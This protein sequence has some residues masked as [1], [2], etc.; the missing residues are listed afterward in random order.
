MDLTHRVADKQ[1]VG[2]ARI[3]YHISYP[4]VLV[5]PVLFMVI[6]LF[7]ARN[8]FGQEWEV[9]TFSTA[10]IPTVTGLIA[11]F[12]RQE[13]Q[14]VTSDL[15]IV[16][17]ICSPVLF[18]PFVYLVTRRHLPAIITSLLMLLPIS[19]ISE[20]VAL[21]LE[22]GL[23]E[24]D[25]AHVVAFTL[26]A[27]TLSFFYFFVRTGKKMWLALLI[28]SAALVSAVSFFTQFMMICCWFF[29]T[30]S[31]I[32]LGNSLIKSKRFIGATLLHI[33]V[34]FVVYNV[35]A[36]PMFVTQSGRAAVSTV[37]DLIPLLFFLV[38][39][40]GTFAFLIFDRRP[41]L[42]PFFIAASLTLT[43]Y[44][45]RF[46]GDS[47]GSDF[48]IAGDRYEV[49]LTFTRAFLIGLII[50]W[51]FDAL[52][53]G[54]LLQKLPALYE[55]REALALTGVLIIIIG[56]TGMVLFIPRTL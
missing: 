32:L 31:E 34:V 21:P 33:L 47:F 42:Q 23:A 4:G 28:L 50:M 45:L 22:L 36:V 30:L 29:I 24:N 54:K 53:V 48:P 13:V 44:L 5:I 3:M 11:S 25:G 1:R 15:V 12:I 43:F 17:F 9:G 46:L 16:S 19:L 18:Y 40:L 55:K 6:A 41:S 10:L 52:R 27:P 20:T 39:V 8:L 7:S 26:L 51:F 14:V 37:F 49:E 56:L 35:A 38:P 2:L